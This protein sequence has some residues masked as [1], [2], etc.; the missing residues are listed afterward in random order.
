MLKGSYT[1]EQL[2]A[3]GSVNSALGRERG[4][5][6]LLHFAWGADGALLATGVRPGN[7]ARVVR[8]QSACNGELYV[9]DTLLLPAN[10]SSQLDTFFGETA[11]VIKLLGDEDAC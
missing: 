2:V 3:A 7:V 1:P 6:I 11:A 4:A 8:R 9:I 5:D 10:S